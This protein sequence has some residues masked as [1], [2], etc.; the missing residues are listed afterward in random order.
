MTTVLY[1]LG[2]RPEVIRSARIL[3]ILAA[4]PDVRLV[5]VNTGQHYDEAMMSG[6]L[7]ELEVPQ[8]DHNL[9][10]G[11]A[12]PVT[13]TALI[14]QAVGTVIQEE[15]PDTVC[16]FGDT[17]ST[18]GGGIAAAKAAT[19]LVH[20]EAGCRSFDRRMPE[21]I[22]RRAVDH[23][24]D[25]L[26]AVSEL[27]AHNLER[28]QVLGEVRVVGDPQF[29]IFQTNS[30]SLEVGRDGDRGLITIHRQENADDP[31]RLAAILAGIAEVDPA[32]RWTF[33]VHPRTAKAMGPPP[34]SIETVEPMLYGELLEAL[35]SSSVCVT[36]SGGLQKEAF[37]ARVPCV[38][39]RETTE[40][41]ETVASGANELTQPDGV[42][43]AVRRA[44]AK[45]L[46]RDYENPYGDGRASESI[47][48]ILRE[49]TR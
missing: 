23:V 4:D 3:Q 8:V 48:Q 2:T 35:L 38:T 25:L 47:A 9:D 5:I 10:V 11:S 24:A 14:V 39:V 26:L 45:H 37:W 29:D 20:I 43:A 32:M 17:N 36:D 44:R 34:N 31:V 7:R 28:E 42:L 21:E 12:D 18:L 16:V 13:Q 49:W 27:A 6:L 41:M 19:A 1:V 22:N 15:S 33:P 40:W 30:Q 46:P